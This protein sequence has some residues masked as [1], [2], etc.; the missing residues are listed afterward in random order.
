[1]SDKSR[2]GKQL[3]QPWA[4]FYNAS[5]ETV[6][7][8]GVLKIKGTES[9]K[10]NALT[11]LKP[12]NTASDC[13][14]ALNLG[15]PVASTKTGKATVM[16]GGFALYDNNGGSDTPA[17]GEEWGPKDDW[18]LHKGEAGFII[19]GDP[20]DF[21]YNSGTYR[22]VRVTL[23]SS[24]Q[25]ITVFRLVNCDDS[26]KVI[27]ADNIEIADHLPGEEHAEFPVAVLRIEGELSCWK[28]TGVAPLCKTGECVEIIGWSRNCSVCLDELC[29]ILTPCEGG[30]PTFVQ[31]N[32]W[33]DYID[34]VV[35]IGGECYTVTLADGCV[36]VDE[37]T[38]VDEIQS[39]Y[40][41]CTKCDQCYELT[42]CNGSGEATVLYVGNDLAEHAEVDDGEDVV[43]QIWS[44][45]GTCYEV[46]DFQ[47][48]CTETPEFFPFYD[49]FGFTT[50]PGG[51][52]REL[53][54]NSCCYKLIPCSGMIEA[55][56]LEVIPDAG[57]P[58]LWEFVK[59]EPETCGDGCTHYP[60]NGRVIRLAN[61]FCYIVTKPISPLCEDPDVGLGTV[62]EIY[63]PEGDGDP[64]SDEDA[65]DFCLRTKWKMCESPFTE[66]ITY[67]DLREFNTGGTPFAST[68]V[69]KRAEDGLC[70][71]WDS[72]E[73][74][75]GGG[76]DFTVE[77]AY[78][79]CAICLDPRVK[80]TPSCGGG[81][82]CAD[83]STS[84]DSSHV[85]IILL[86]EDAP[87]L[88][89][90]IGQYVK[91][92]GVCYLVSWTDEAATTTDEPCFYGPY[93]DCEDCRGGTSAL[94]LAV[95]KVDGTI[96]GMR[97]E[98]AFNVCGEIEL[99]E[100]C[101]E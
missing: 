85:P 84:T 3:G 60:S 15:Q 78:E 46:T 18:L 6:P 53:N 17:P 12:N 38:T 1:M 55:P 97:V 42:P 29:W 89:E 49:F 64:D 25:P 96:V 65:C 99:T 21:S 19:V 47:S 13:V 4:R 58:D 68:W 52:R 91:I 100:P 70:Y 62:R 33:A 72:N 86:D 24:P 101:P 8:F 9:T 88:V 63:E 98:G 92:E 69:L 66:I 93:E 28:L 20:E 40:L 23:A 44:L 35:K 31:G 34:R 54:C 43:G 90:L 59:H 14:F 83:G 51:L 2:D 57:D 36:G 27:Y 79:T 45:E 32:G 16:L 37:N 11:G 67:S 95:K 87:Q 7:P 48:P 30:S 80:L 22:R 39:H 10:A 82:E 41:N 50:I 56:T 71:E 74:A 26:T 5:G 61:G 73:V 81:C 77:E 75:G 94:T 76:V